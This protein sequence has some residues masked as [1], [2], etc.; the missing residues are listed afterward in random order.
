VG[1]NPQ[2][3]AVDLR[4]GL[5]VV[6][7]QGSN[8]ASIVSLSGNTVV[9]TVS[10]DPG[11]TGVAIDPG[12]GLAVVTASNANLV[13]MFAV[14]TSPGAV[15]S[16]AVEQ[17]PVAIAVDPIRHFAAVANATSNS[18]SLV[19]L[20]GSAATEHIAASGLPAGVAFDPVSA[21]FLVA[22]SLNNRVL[23]LDP[24]SR[25]TTPL[26]VGINPTS[27]AY[28]FAASTLV[29]TNSS[30]QTMTVVDFLEGRVRAVLSVRPSSQ[31]A[32]DIHPFSNLA[33]IAD[34]AGNRVF[35]WP[36]PR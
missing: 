3:V 19:D 1:T 16:F 22:A 11:P 23:V 8:N 6:A 4:T 31:F 7:N 10:T 18:V 29:T 17:R 24:T 12:L 27:I 30:S 25:S 26:R 32:V 36:L 5:A 33:V 9:A 20:T 35:L 21:T 14:S 13:N 2:G 34:S 15:T 28:N